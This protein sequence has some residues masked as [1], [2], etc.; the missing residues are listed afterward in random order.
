MPYQLG[1]GELLQVLFYWLMI[2]VPQVYLGSFC[3]FKTKA[4]S[5][6]CSVNR[7]PRGVENLPFYLRDEF[8]GVLGGVLPFR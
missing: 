4:V 5:L 3:G 1:L 2:F 8:V 6:P 7:I